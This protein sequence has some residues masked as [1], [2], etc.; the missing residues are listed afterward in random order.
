MISKKKAVFN[1]SGGK[2]SALALQK[3]LEERSFEIVSLL[4]TINEDDHRSS[5]HAIPLEILQQQA[6]SIGIPLYTVSMSKELKGYADKMLEAV[7]HFKK[8]GVTHFAFG[9]LF[10]ENIKDYRERNLHPHGIEVVEP[11][12][13]K[14][15]REVMDEFLASGIQAKIIVTKADKLNATYIGKDL[16]KELVESFPKD[17]DCCGEYGEYHTL[18]YAGSL[19]K[20][21]IE[22]SIDSIK[23]HSYEVQLENGVVEPYHYFQAEILNTSIP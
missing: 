14:A 11:L 7:M 15:S 6:D 1:W 23:K 19:F 18:A 9:D 17:I 16:T 10:L 2:D 5:I 3:L 20:K 12:W 21:E 4:A 13:N 8:S 22:F